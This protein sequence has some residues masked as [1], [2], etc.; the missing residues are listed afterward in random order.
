MTARRTLAVLAGVVMFAGF[1][2]LGVWQVQRLHWK[3]DL[4]ARVDARVHAPAAP[5]PGPAD[6]RRVTAASDEYRHVH[7]S[8]VFEND[9]ET[10]VQAVTEL[11]PGYWVMTPLRTD[12]GEE[13]L[14]NRGFV[15]P[16]QSAPAARRAGLPASR[17]TVTGLLRITEPRGGFL[18]ANQPAAGRWFS[19]DVAAIARAR[20]LKQPAPYFIDADSA[21]NPGGWPRGGLTV[22]RFRNSHLVYAFTWFGLAAMTAAWG[23]WPLFESFRRRRAAA[24]P[25]IG[26]TAA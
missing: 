25:G 9:K 2:A 13:I 10:L 22:V 23:A 15:P 7:V 20:D 3:L 12:G 24:L 4:I 11:G 14:V 21:P 17:T 16:E 6:W 8:G 26:S 1:I 18:R 5:P 19:R